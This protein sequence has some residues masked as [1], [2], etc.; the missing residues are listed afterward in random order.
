MRRED[1]HRRTAECSREAREHA[2][3]GAVRVHDRRPL[4]PDQGDELDE[5]E[6]VAWTD[7]AAH[8]PKLDPARARSSGGG[9]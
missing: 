9:A 8:V 6:Q 5:P 1:D 2:G 4:S 3:L 7:R